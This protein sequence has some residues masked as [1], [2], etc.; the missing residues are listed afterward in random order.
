MAAQRRTP[1]SLYMLSLPR[2]PLSATSGD[3]P[4]TPINQQRSPITFS[5]ARYSRASSE[6]WNSTDDGS[7]ESAEWDD[8][9]IQ[10]LAKTLDN[11]PSHVFTPFIGQI[12]PANLLDRLARGIQHKNSD[13]PHTHR[14]T[15]QM[16]AQLARQRAS[17]APLDMVQEDPQ[18]PE[19]ESGARAEESR[20]RPLYRKN[21]MDFIPPSTSKENVQI[22]RLSN[23]L[24][25]A[26]RF[27]SFH[28]Y[29]KCTSSSQCQVSPPPSSLP[30][31][32]AAPTPPPSSR[33]PPIAPGIR[34]SHSAATSSG[35][36]EASYAVPALPSRIPRPTSP[37]ASLSSL[38]SLRK[39]N[40][41]PKASS[42]EDSRENL[43]RSGGSGKGRSSTPLNTVSEVDMTYTHP[44]LKRAPSYGVIAQQKKAADKADRMD[45]DSPSP[46]KPADPKLRK[47]S[48]SSDEEEKK[49]QKATKRAKMIHRKPSYLGAEL[50]VV[51]PAQDPKPLEIPPYPK[52]KQLTRDD[53]L[54]SLV[55]ANSSSSSASV[56]TDSLMLDSAATSR[57]SLNTAVSSNSQN[58]ASKR[59]EQ[60][61]TPPATARPTVKSPPE[62]VTSPMS[63]SDATPPKPRTLRRMG[64]KMARLSEES[65]NATISIGS[66]SQVTG[67]EAL[68]ELEKR[69]EME[70]AWRKKERQF[71][72][73]EK[74]E[75]SEQMVVGSSRGAGRNQ[76]ISVSTVRM[77]DVGSPRS[78]QGAPATPSQKDK[79]KGKTSRRPQLRLNLARKISFG[80]LTEDQPAQ[81]S[82]SGALGLTLSSP[83]EEGGVPGKPLKEPRGRYLF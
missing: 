56:S 70:A 26:D 55:T 78:P 18:Q 67:K 43:A 33:R 14:A 21:S 37:S 61:L 20:K 8:A 74:I 30:S 5:P 46:V 17:S 75:E 50:K 11:L 51:V 80:S 34:R 64:A 35:S 65:N 7:T 53:S 23:R 76:M 13:W 10:V 73:R 27:F 19:E 66:S 68:A 57:T 12:P 77:G 71:L 36:S 58:V 3:G 45:I 44:R 38:G 4:L 24:Q 48:E 54:E 62:L 79:S 39:S 32:E 40:Y 15:R 47:G 52:A 2:P 1:S 81:G 63:I 31:R 6:S 42:S 69:L 82:S 29:S 25:R 60:S 41:V 59:K 83:F 72:K 16:L 49:R 22:N 28:P 9:D